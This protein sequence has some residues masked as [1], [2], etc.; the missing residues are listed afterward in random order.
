MQNSMTIKLREEWRALN[1]KISQH[2]KTIKTNSASGQIFSD[3]YLTWV[4]ELI[5]RRDYLTN[6]I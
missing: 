2:Q 3:E 5:C 6:L 4:N 1:L